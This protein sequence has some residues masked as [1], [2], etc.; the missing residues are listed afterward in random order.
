M[1]K[2]NDIETVIFKLA[3]LAKAMMSEKISAINAEKNDGIILGDIS[4]NAWFFQS[5]D[6]GNHNYDPFIL[7]F[8]DDL[9]AQGEGRAISRKCQLEFDIFLVNDYSVDIQRK[10][11]RYQRCLEDTLLDCWGKIEPMYNLEIQSL[12]PV[13]VKMQNSSNIHKVFGVTINFEIA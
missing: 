13:D 3:D 4:S 6:D 9:T 1:A 7:Y 2:I 12:T 11:L 8:I 5:L 10:I